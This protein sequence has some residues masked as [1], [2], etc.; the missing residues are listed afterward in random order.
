MILKSLQPKL[1]YLHFSIWL[2]FGS[3]SFGSHNFAVT[4]IFKRSIPKL[5][6][7]YKNHLYPVLLIISRASVVKSSQKHHAR[8]IISHL[9][10]SHPKLFL[11]SQNMCVKSLYCYKSRTWVGKSRVEFINSTRKYEN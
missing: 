2:F 3:R 10:V 6:G 11:Q 8:S 9:L 1:S 5:S 4:Q 7:F